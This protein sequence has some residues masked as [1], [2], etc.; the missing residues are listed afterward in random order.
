MTFE[1]FLI[2]AKKVY[3]FKIGIAGVLPENCEDMLKTCLEKYGVNNM[4]SGKKTPIQ[5][6]PLDFPQLQNMEVT[7]FETELNYPT[8]SQVLQEYLGQ[9]CNIDQSFII[10]RNPMEPQEQYQEETQDSEY[11]AKL[12]TEELESVDGQKEVGNN[13]V[14]DLLKELETARK[15][16]GFDTVDGPV[17]ESKD[18]DDSE[19]TKS[20][21]GS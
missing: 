19:N 18:I 21:I 15:E 5:E 20:A 6:R 17:G 11:V 10:V 3:P 12:T 1:K 7:Y 8:T 13:R 14:M 9:C 4:T 2:E 16:R